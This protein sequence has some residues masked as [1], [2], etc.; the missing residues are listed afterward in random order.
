[1]GEVHSVISLLLPWME[2]LHSFFSYTTGNRVTLITKARW[3][4]CTQWLVSY[5]HE[6]QFLKFVTWWRACFRWSLYYILYPGGSS[7]GVGWGQKPFFFQNNNK[8]NEWSLPYLSYYNICW[9]PTLPWLFTK[10]FN[11]PAI[12][13]LPVV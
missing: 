6:C 8:K 7:D 3:V 11:Q 4:K 12:Y 2:F 9:V 1:M 5:C 13:L 10:V